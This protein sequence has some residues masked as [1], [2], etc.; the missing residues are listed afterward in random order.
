MSKTQGLVMQISLPSTTF[1]IQEL[2]LLS[3]GTTLPPPS[4]PILPLPAGWPWAGYLTS[5]VVPSLMKW[6]NKS[7]LRGLFNEIMGTQVTGIHGCTVNMSYFSPLPSNC[8]ISGSP[9]L[10]SDPCGTGLCVFFLPDTH[11]RPPSP[12]HTHTLHQ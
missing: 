7:C 1:P 11:P 9:D 10:H 6:K 3:S 4:N 5:K 12:P 2:P 8:V